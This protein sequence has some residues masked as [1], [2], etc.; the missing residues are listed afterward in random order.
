MF[1]GTQDTAISKTTYDRNGNEIDT[2]LKFGTRDRWVRSYDRNGFCTEER[3]YQNDQLQYINRYIYETDERG[4]WIKQS[5]TSYDP[6]APSDPIPT[7]ATYR[8]ITYYDQ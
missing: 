1:S 4:N 8:K 2:Q 6:K 7:S 3:V 5:G